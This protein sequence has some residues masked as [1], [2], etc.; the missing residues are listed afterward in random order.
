MA[1]RTTAPSGVIDHLIRLPTDNTEARLRKGLMISAGIN[2]VV[3]AL[4]FSASTLRDAPRN[5]VKYTPINIVGDDLKNVQI[6]VKNPPPQ[7]KKVARREPERRPRPVPKVTRR[8]P[9]KPVQVAKAKPEPVR[10]KPVA[11]R[12]PEAVVE[13]P[14]PVARRTP[15]PSAPTPVNNSA[16]SARVAT[17]TAVSA[18][19]NTNRALSPNANANANVSVSAPTFNRANP[20]AGGNTLATASRSV[21]SSAA[22]SSVG[23]TVA[24]RPAASAPATAGSNTAEPS[25]RAA[26]AGVAGTRGGYTSFGASAS[27]V[28]T[29]VAAISA[30]TFVGRMRPAMGST[31]LIANQSAVMTAAMS[32]DGKA[33]SGLA[34]I[35]G[36]RGTVASSIAIGRASAQRAG[37]GAASVGSGGRAVGTTDDSRAIG[38][39]QASGIGNAKGP[40]LGNS[41]VVA[42][43]RGTVGAAAD[44]DGNGVGVASAGNRLGDAVAGSTRSAGGGSG[45]TGQ[46]GTARAGG[47]GGSSVAAGAGSTG[48]LTVESKGAAASE[49]IRRPQ[50]PDTSKLGERNNAGGSA[51]N[52]ND[53]PK[54]TFQP[55]VDLSPELRKRRFNGRVL[56]EVVVEAD[57]SHVERIL[58]SSGDSDVDNAVRAAF[59]RWKW[60]PGYRDGQKVRATTKYEYRIKVKE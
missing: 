42:I 6:P 1:S 8:T 32:D 55:D 59:R 3:I 9:P 4:A 16:E 41:S 2:V 56:V 12:K 45:P 33:N 54:P 15:A 22:E 28:G 44:G 48:P 52:R 50:A 60:E 36:A 20:S 46:V 7:P 43:G 30:P 10:P 37:S 29:N 39:A 21:S 53:D 26:S 47:G 19:V 17:N 23:A 35:Q 24:S 58:L 27:G 51:A 11:R 40:S 34:T 13:R 49:E 57:G 14:A 31:A 25:V 18:S 5:D 38:V